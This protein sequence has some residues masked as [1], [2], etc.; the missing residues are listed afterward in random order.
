[1]IKELYKWFNKLPKYRQLFIIIVI[2][3]IL[4]GLIL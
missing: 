4:F 3:L 1:M 2:I